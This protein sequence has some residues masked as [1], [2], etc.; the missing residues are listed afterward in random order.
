MG[1]PNTEIWILSI[2]TTVVVVAMSFAWLA[3]DRWVGSPP[4]TPR[5]RVD[6]KPERHPDQP[7][8][9]VQRKSDRIAVWRAGHGAGP[10]CEIFRRLQGDGWVVKRHTCVHARGHYLP[11]LKVVDD[12][13]VWTEEDA[14][15]ARAVEILETVRHN[16]AADRQAKAQVDLDTGRH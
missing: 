6:L 7:E 2:I 14:A 9:L 3:V 11:R 12:P 5:R 15:I 4:A 16:Y 13:R 8:Y 10:R 1:N